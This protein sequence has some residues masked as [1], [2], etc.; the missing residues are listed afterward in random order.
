MCSVL[1]PVALL[2]LIVAVIWPLTSV[3]TARLR[4]R[5]IE[6]DGWV[7]GLLWRLRVQALHDGES[8][9]ELSIELRLLHVITLRRKFPAVVSSWRR[10]VPAWR[11]VRQWEAGIREADTREAGEDTPSDTVVTWAELKEWHQTWK[12]WQPMV[13]ALGRGATFV[14]RR[15]RVTSLRIRLRFGLGDA[16]VTARAHGVVW[17]LVGTG[18]GIA[19]RKV[20][21]VTKPDV[22]I[23][24]IYNARV[25]HLDV[26]GAASVP[27]VIAAAGVFIS[28]FAYGR[29]RREST[30]KAPAAVGG[31]KT[32]G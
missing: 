15:L 32:A 12:R 2:L 14:R 5:V 8:H 10:F 25:I 4:T 28:L 22:A 11:L 19:S 16:A 6:L 31:A 30:G 23:L 29:A 17:A 26:S 3:F 18:L 27:Q 1:C 24:P 13:R 21:L 20:N 9:D 7:A